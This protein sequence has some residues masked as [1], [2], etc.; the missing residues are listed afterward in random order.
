M[1]KTPTPE[2]TDRSN[3]I[4]RLIRMKKFWIAVS[5]LVLFFVGV[6]RYEHYILQPPENDWPEVTAE[7]LRSEYWYATE[8]GQRLTGELERLVDSR[9]MR[10]ATGLYYQQYKKRFSPGIK[11]TQYVKVGPEQYPEIH[12][13]VVDACGSFGRLDGSSVTVPNVYV[14]WTG[15]RDFEVTNFTRPSIVIG[16]D[17]LWA[18]KPEEL[19]YLIARQIGHI[20]CKH[21]YFLDALKGARALLN[22]ALPDFIGRAILGGLATPLLEWSKESHITADRAGLLV[23]GDVD[24][25]CQALIKLNIQASLDDFYGLASPE[26][27]AAQARILS[28]D[29]MT[30]ASAAL[31]EMRNP[32]PF[33]TTR[34]GDL[35]QFHAANASLFMD[36]KLAKDR[37]STFDPG[38]LDED[39]E[40]P[41]AEGDTSGSP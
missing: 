32:N 17:F 14:G 29:R 37:I 5:L 21:V 39:V 24:T 4:F 11:N 12:A 9:P 7:D 18:Y 8:E 33:L 20:H 2:R 34:V 41:K 10:F 13:M 35:L 6:A 22:T 23:T 27:F 15:R 26:A 3:P 31:A 1:E 16:N 28:E 19:R 38:I 25:A 40:A 36:R 30:T